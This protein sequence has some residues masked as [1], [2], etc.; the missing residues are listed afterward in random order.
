MRAA[1]VLATALLA[2][3]LASADQVYKW[4]DENGVWHFTDKRP[5]DQQEVEVSIIEPEPQDMV[6]M[7]RTGPDQ[8]PAF[9]FFNRYH[10]PVQVEISAR[11]A[12]NL[13]THPPLPAR[14]VLQGQQEQQ[15]VEAAPAD[16]ARGYR[17]QLAYRYMPGPP[18]PDPLPVLDLPPPFEAGQRWMISQG[19]E[20]GT[21]TDVANLHAVDIA[22]P[23]GTPVL[24]VMAGQ[25]M[26]AED[27]YH[28][29]GTRSDRY[30]ERAN[31]VRLL[32]ADGSMS[33]YAHLAPGSIEVRPGARVPAGAVIGR[34]GN[35]GF[36]SGPHLH[37][38]LQQNMDMQLVSRP[39]RFPVGVGE[40]REPR[41]GDEVWGK[42]SAR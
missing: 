26:E 19:F 15:L 36:S 28:S 12:E 27:G 29:G 32:H 11:Q 40:P 23:E 4:Q 39:F 22:M 24:A 38:V 8:A 41:V 5:A 9:V 30:I 37:F 6:T 2:G 18:V 33:V 16:P 17:F 20:T 25:V 10:G 35:T 34:S 42:L 14:F 3:G 31:R 7:R 1:A 21:H 13:S